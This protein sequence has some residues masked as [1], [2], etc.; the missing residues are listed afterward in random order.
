MALPSNVEHTNWVPHC[1]ALLESEMSQVVS[2][3]LQG[4]QPAQSKPSMWELRFKTNKKITKTG[5]VL[6]TKYAR[7]SGR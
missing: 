2:D 7:D 5:L 1:S 6:K 3:L 4:T